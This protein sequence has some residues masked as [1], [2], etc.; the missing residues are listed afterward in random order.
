MRN[1]LLALAV[2]GIGTTALAGD[3]D[4]SVG[5]DV[6]YSSIS[7]EDDD[8]STDTENL[9]FP[10]RLFGELKL[11]RINKLQVGW[12]QLDFDVDA[13]PS[14]DM[15]A[16]YEGNQIDAVWLHQVRFGRN[17]KPWLGVGLRTS[18][19]DIKGKHLVDHDGYLVDRF[20]STSE[21]QMAGL[22]EGYYEWQL[23]R[24]GWY[25]NAALTYD[26]PIGDGFEGLGVGVG[27]KSEF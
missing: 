12:R 20:E 14:G 10:F 18:M 6:G 26:V 3:V 15:G 2:A 23:T 25:L 7:Y 5:V 13:T 22:L 19:F 11:D 17:F 24:S 21:T 16:T 27:I 4:Y 9:A 8:G 1:T